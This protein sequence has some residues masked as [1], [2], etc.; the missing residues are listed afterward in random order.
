[1]PPS[2]PVV[3][4]RR[5]WEAAHDADAVDKELLLPADYAEDGERWS[6]W[7]ATTTCWA[8]GRFSCC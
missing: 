5:E 3:V 2:V 8:T 4:Q 6:S 1:M 7:T